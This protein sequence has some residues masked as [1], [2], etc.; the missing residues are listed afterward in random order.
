VLGD[1]STEHNIPINNRLGLFRALLYQLLAKQAFVN[2]SVF[3]LSFVS[4][5]LFLFSAYTMRLFG[6][7]VG[8]ALCA[9][10]ISV[11]ALPYGVDSGE[12][13][14]EPIRWPIQVTA[15]SQVPQQYVA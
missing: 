11:E 7:L 12:T 1:G 6:A 15:G 8:L 13:S 10:T 5:G 9:A 4:L 14:V 2:I 3:L